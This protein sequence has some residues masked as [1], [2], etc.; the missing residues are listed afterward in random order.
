M[1]IL[2]LSDL[3][4][5]CKSD[6]TKW[7]EYIGNILENDDIDVVVITGDVI[8]SNYDSDPYGML[9]SICHGKKVV[10]NLGNHEFF[11]RTVD[12]TLD[13][14][15]RKYKPDQYDVHCLDIVH[16][17]DVDH[18]RFLGNVLWYDGSMSTV[19][20]Q[21]ME[22]FADG[23]WADRWVKGL[24]Y[25]KENQRCVKHIKESVGED[26]MINILCTHTCPHNDLNMH[27]VKQSSDFNAYSGMANLL[28]TVNVDYA[29]CGH[30]HWKTIGK[31]IEG[32]CCINVGNDYY[33]P[34]QYFVLDL[35]SEKEK[36]KEKEKE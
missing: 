9:H 28:R 5:Q 25:I 13:H 22:T 20:C 19:P 32:T 21:I 2:C 29:I 4:I 6:K 18:V 33:P 31:I 17:H 24:N 11:Y 34:Y 14:Y 23:R 36:E 27:R 12:E 35:G 26:W 1:K 7:T 3:H 8:E 16:Y 10:F 15:K 30:T